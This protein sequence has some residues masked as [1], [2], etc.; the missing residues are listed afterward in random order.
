MNDPCPNVVLEAMACGLPVVHAASGGT[1][2]LV[3]DEAGDRRP[4]PTTA[5]SATTRRRPTRSRPRC[6]R[7][8]DATR[9]GSLRRLGG[10]R[11]SA[12]R[13]TVW[14]DRHAELFAAL[15]ERQPV[16]ARPAR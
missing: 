3:G 9:D 5:S 4:P 1:V 11:S 6:L 12:S 2:E 7:V 14:L 16:A 15:T 10:G 13:S 8:L